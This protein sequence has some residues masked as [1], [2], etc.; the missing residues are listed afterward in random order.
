MQPDH[1]AP[2]V[3]IVDDDAPLLQ[4]HRRAFARESYRVET[5][6]DGETAARALQH[7]PFDVIVSDIDMP[8][9]DGI[10]LLE[11]VRAHDLDVPVILLTGTPSLA[12]AV[13]AIELGALRYVVKP[14]ALQ[15]LV[16]VA[17]DAVHGCRVARAKRQRGLVLGNNV[18]GRYEL[19]RDLGRG[20]AGLVF[21]A[22]HTFTGR[23]VALKVLSPDVPKSQLAELR[24]RSAREARALAAVRHPGVVE[25]LDGGV[26]DDGT[27]YIVMERLDGRTL[28]G[29]LTTRGKLSSEE[30]IAL[31][32]QTCSALDAVHAAGI[33]HRDLKPSN[34]IVVRDHEGHERIKLVDFGIAQVDEQ[35]PSKLTGIGALI[36]TPAYM[37]LEQLCALDDV[38]RRADIYALGITMFEC[39]TGEVPY[40]GPYPRILLQVSAAG[41]APSLPPEVDAKLAGIV[42]RA[43]AKQ[44]DDRFATAKELESAI[45]KAFPRS[46]T[47]TT[48]LG[49]LPL[50]IPAQE[51]AAQRRRLPRA[52]YA[53]PVHILL[54]YGTIDGRS[55]DISEGGLLIICREQCENDVP[56]HVRF[57]LPIEGRIVSCEAHLRWQR[58]AQQ[59]NPDGPRALGLE[60]INPSEALR[61]S[62]KRYVALMGDGARVNEFAT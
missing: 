48:L 10:A 47:R 49:P 4:I 23:S 8:G 7:G 37:A 5:A 27:P 50:P 13:K 62:V 58:A 32:L 14:I 56:V 3:L 61:A 40:L 57:A 17:N 53:T 33:V 22:I 38:D 25:I 15:A 45:R 12:T 6:P 20:A 2:S 26:L 11:R 16:K 29:L 60:F 24:V 44:R 9:M 35:K 21:E 42:A 39:L 31:V 55:E 59:G 18:D 19:R 28:E 30:T 54:L 36:G 34:L 43:I 52:P 51:S 1:T 41:P 46:S